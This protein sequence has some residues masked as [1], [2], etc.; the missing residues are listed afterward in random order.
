V[1]APKATTWLLGAV[2]AL[3]LLPSNVVA[4]ALPLLEV[5]WS[6]SSTE[7]GVVFAAYQLGYV[8]AVLL[9]L[10]LTDRV[11]TGRVITLSAAATG[12]SFVAFPLLAHDVLSASLLRLV[13]GAGLAGVYMPGVRVVAAAASAERRG[14]VVSLYV[15]C[16]YV[17]AALSLW[18]S[19]VL[20]NL[21]DWR[22][23]ALTLGAVSVAAL[24]LA[25]LGTRGAPAPQ[26]R[27]ARLRL[28]VLKNGPV[29]RTILAY[30][31]HSWELYVSRGW[32]AA[33]LATV[34]AGRGVG[35]VE[36]AALGSQAA[37]LM[38][39]TGAVGVWLGGHF[40]DRFGRARAA[41]AIALTS[42]ALS[43]AFGW[44]ADLPWEL[45]LMV[46]CAYGLVMGA[47][48]AVYSTAVTELAPEGQLGSA[49]A[50][51][52]FI[53][54]SASALSPVAAGFVL[55]LGGGFGGVFMLAGLVGMA[56]ASALLPLT[57]RS[58]FQVP[59]ST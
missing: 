51:Q 39:G 4:A 19:G 29:L 37:G 30:S 25:L 5:D 38:A 6:A 52:A 20:L 24:P 54:F 32:L 7:L 11:P 36:S 16:F 41:M 15:S 43:L 47:D 21:G 33:Y 45:L 2:L 59:R 40:S 3:A 50:A 35:P 44:L 55:D 22:F 42:G 28:S 26:G 53:G 48:S 10:P 56:C 58:T 18:A 46:G 49:Q 8:G 17:G 31:G 57:R 34:L 27:T 23:A 1:P 14:L 13:S 12:L 9:L